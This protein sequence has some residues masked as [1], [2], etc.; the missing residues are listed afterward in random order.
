MG[1]GDEGFGGLVARYWRSLCNLFA[2]GQS[3]AAAMGLSSVAAVRRD[4]HRD[5]Q[6]QAGDVPAAGSEGRGDRPSPPPMTPDIPTSFGPE[7]VRKAIADTLNT[8]L[9][10]PEGHNGAAVVY[11]NGEKVETAVAT[12]VLKND[13]FEWDVGT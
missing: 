7:A 11:A 2:F 5:D 3:L 8:S 12:K 6:R 9:D 1:N 10:I 13:K 4:D